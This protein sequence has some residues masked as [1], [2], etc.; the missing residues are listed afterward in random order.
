MSTCSSAAF[1]S[2]WQKPLFIYSKISPLQWPRLQKAVENSLHEGWRYVACGE[3][4]SYLGKIFYQVNAEVLEA[5]QAHIYSQFRAWELQENISEL[6]I[7]PWLQV[8][9]TLDERA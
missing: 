7:G 3:H 2:P 6:W 5:I 1:D 4:E 9:D 8:E